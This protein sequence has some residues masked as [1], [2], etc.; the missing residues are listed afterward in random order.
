MSFIRLTPSAHLIWD[1]EG[2]DLK[3]APDSKTTPGDPTDIG[4][5]FQRNWQ[6]GIFRLSAEKTTLTGLSA[7][8][9]AVLRFWTKRRPFVLRAPG[10]AGLPAAGLSATGGPHT[11]DGA[12]S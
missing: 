8:H 10:K 11:A 6:E 9:A 3:S 4:N 2:C 1:A 5:T 7:D 12:W